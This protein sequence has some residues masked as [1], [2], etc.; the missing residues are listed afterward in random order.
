MENNGGYQRVK[1]F[2]D[3]LA[4]F[5]TIYEHNGHPDKRTDRRTDRHHMTTKAAIAAWQGCSRAEKNDKQTD[6]QRDG[7]RRCVNSRLATI[8]LGKHDKPPALAL[9]TFTRVIYNPLQ[10]AA[11][12]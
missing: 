4:G 8:R 12:W 7:Y 2:E 3:M 10:G 5:D 1:K 6:R 11:T 9:S